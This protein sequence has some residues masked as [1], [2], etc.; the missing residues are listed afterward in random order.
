MFM[1]RPC[2]SVVIP[3]FNEQEVLREAHRRL[4]AVMKGTG[5]SYELIFVNDGSRDDT[6]NILKTLAQEDPNV[7]AIHFSRNFGH[8]MAITAGM[9]HATGD[10]ILVIDADL[11]DPPEVIPEMMKK[12]REGYQVVYGQR[13]KRHGETF[14]KKATAKIF[15]RTLRRMTEVDIPVDTGD[16]RLIDRR[17]RDALS[18]LPEHNRYVRGLVSWVGFR[19]IGV[20]YVREERFAGESKY[21]LSAMLKF[22]GDALTSFSYKPLKLSM[23]L[24]LLACFISVLGLLT[25]AVLALFTSLYVP[26]FLYPL[27]ILGFF[28][29]LLLILVGL[30]GSYLGRIYEEVKGRPLYLIAEKDGFAETQE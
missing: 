23:A 6:M 2:V 3:A 1:L 4:S 28:Y 8:Q 5:E 13:K 9:E 30:I 22:A 10:A 16:F 19:Q 7:K 12:W 17:V 15:Y 27:F 21:P 14:F 29:G 26:G 18:Q 24:G 20:E 25:A 11:Q